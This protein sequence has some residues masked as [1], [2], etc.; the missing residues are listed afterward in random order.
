MTF[1]LKNK[2]KLILKKLQKSRTGNGKSTKIWTNNG[3]D[4]LQTIT[5]TVCNKCS[6][7]GNKREWE[8]G[9]QSIKKERKF[10]ITD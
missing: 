10:E 6:N 4:S 1:P 2:M 9:E 7:K 3:G 5:G 8:Q